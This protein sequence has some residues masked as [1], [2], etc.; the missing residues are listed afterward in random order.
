MAIYLIRIKRITGLGVYKLVCNR[1]QNMVVNQPKQ[2]KKSIR[3]NYI[4]SKTAWITVIMQ[5]VL[6]FSVSLRAF[7]DDLKILRSGLVPNLFKT[8]F[9]CQRATVMRFCSFVSMCSF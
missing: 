7:Q 1:P 8:T 6:A 5:K 9:M 4:I 3:N 2:Y